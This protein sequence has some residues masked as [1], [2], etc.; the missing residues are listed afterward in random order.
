VAASDPALIVA[1]DPLTGRIL[2]TV[3]MGVRTDAIAADPITAR[4]YAVSSGPIAVDV[5]RDPSR[6]P[7]DTSNVRI[8]FEVKGGLG[9]VQD[10]LA[11]QPSGQAEL[12]RRG[13]A[14]RTADLGKERLEELVTMF[15]EDDFFALRPRYNAPRPI[16]DAL[17]FSIMFRDGQREHTVVMSTGGAP[18]A[19]LLDIIR[20]LERVRQELILPAETVG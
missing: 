11:V 16:P 20:R 7:R 15:Y 5:V 12:E 18:P 4:L 14:T 6:P 3:E 2:G 9:G 17:E 19:M 13:V 10:V 8:V 1:L